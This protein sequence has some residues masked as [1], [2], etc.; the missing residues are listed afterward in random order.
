MVPLNDGSSLPK[1][2]D[3]GL[4][5]GGA[6]SSKLTGGVSQQ[7]VETLLANPDA[8]RKP[9]EGSNGFSAEAFSWNNL[10]L[11]AV[12]ASAVAWFDG[13]GPI[14]ASEAIARRGFSMPTNVID[15]IF[16][17]FF[18]EEALPLL[19]N[20][21]AEED[22][23]GEQV[24][25]SESA[26]GQKLIQ[27]LS[28]LGVTWNYT[29]TITL[30]ADDDNIGGVLQAELEMQLEGFGQWANGFDTPYVQKFRVYRK[31]D[32]SEQI[33]WSIDALAATRAYTHLDEREI[34]QSEEDGSY[35]VWSAQGAPGVLRNGHVTEE[36]ALPAVAMRAFFLAETPFPSNAWL[37]HMTRSMAYP[38]LSESRYPLPTIVY[39]RDALAAGVMQ[40]HSQ[41][42]ITF[43]HSLFPTVTKMGWRI[44]DMSVEE[45]KIVLPVVSDGA[46]KLSTILED[47]Y[48]NYNID[49]Y[50]APFDLALD[51]AVAFNLDYVPGDTA[52][53]FSQW[54][55]VSMIGMKLEETMNLVY[56]AVDADK[57]GDAEFAGRAFERVATDG[58]G[59]VVTNS[60]NSLVFSHLFPLGEFE[61]AEFLLDMAE[62]LP[63]GYQAINAKSNRGIALYMLG[64][65]DEAEQV[66]REVLD[67]GETQS[68]SEANYY[69]SRICRESGR[70][71]EADELMT[72]CNNAGGYTPFD[73]QDV[74][75]SDGSAQP[76][77]SKP[78][79]AHSSGEGATPRAKFC[80]ECGT[81][82]ADDTHR[83]CVNCGSQ[84]R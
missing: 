47:G 28:D 78:S 66:F 29:N 37:M 35:I 44:N 70:D 23:L 64:R 8:Y 76:I 52:G 3:K 74:R 83:F 71:A 13:L 39:E 49:N 53:G 68:E 80:T 75:I 27:V 20:L 18:G 22:D 79:S 73:A 42:S 84:R 4:G 15:I 24:A 7:S 46:N 16:P 2:S 26:L 61:R 6:S 77:P 5:V 32:G 45:L 82:F 65:H 60:V 11:D 69:L 43:F 67:L 50:P 56:A 10:M 1:S 57:R 17:R 48:R 19:P 36:L 81:Q 51:A 63:A 21:I 9:L 33:F 38:E 72:R 54:V 40:S 58:A 59:I 62:R 31:A 14:P 41:G 25:I 30:G 34:F 55:P 12:G